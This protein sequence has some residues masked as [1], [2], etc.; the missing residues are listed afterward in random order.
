MNNLRN[1]IWTSVLAVACTV[2]L[3]V[4]GILGAME[5]VIAFGFAGVI[6]ATLSGM[7][8]R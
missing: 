1:I 7:A 4:S 6:F 2:G 5:W 8:R 3:L